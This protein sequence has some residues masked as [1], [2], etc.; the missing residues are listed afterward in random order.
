MTTVAHPKR[1]LYLIRATPYGGQRALETL[2][3]ILVSAAFDLPVSVLFLDQG[4]WQLAAGQ[5]TASGIKNMTSQWQVL[6]EYDVTALW[7]CASSL[8]ATG[9]TLND[10]CLP[11]KVLDAAGQRD[12]MHQHDVILND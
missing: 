12:L 5:R 8:A 6:P 1:L 7:A 10:L 2:D 3:A 9:L 4:I 11:V